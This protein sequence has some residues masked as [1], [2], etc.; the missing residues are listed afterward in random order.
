MDFKYQYSYNEHINE[1]LNKVLVNLNT[2]R[3]KFLFIGNESYIVPVIE[4]QKYINKIL[5]ILIDRFQG[6]YKAVCVHYVNDNNEYVYHLKM[7][8]GDRIGDLF[9]LQEMIDHN[10]HHKCE[11]TKDLLRSLEQDRF[12]FITNYKLKELTDYEILQ[13]NKTSN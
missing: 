6:G 11:I 10:Y 5:D 1:Y 7:V 4:S 2:E 8:D 13:G 3:Q 9:D 12:T